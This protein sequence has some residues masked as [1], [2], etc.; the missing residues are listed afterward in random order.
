[1]STLVSPKFCSRIVNPASA[2]NSATLLEEN[3]DDPD[4][5]K[6]PISWLQCHLLRKRLGISNARKQKW[7]ESHDQQ[8]NRDRPQQGH[9]YQERNDVAEERL[10]TGSQSERPTQTRKRFLPRANDRVE[11]KSSTLEAVNLD[12][13]DY[14]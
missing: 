5:R 1:M 14:F 3:P 12:A 10:C 2:A 8:D 7:Q 4:D 11:L 6:S 9:D 13:Y